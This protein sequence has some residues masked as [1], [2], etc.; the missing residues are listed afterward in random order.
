MD[1]QRPLFQVIQMTV[2]LE[3][4]VMKHTAVYNIW[5]ILGN[6]DKVIKRSHA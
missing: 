3:R 6:L 4:G 1:L 2:Y 5:D